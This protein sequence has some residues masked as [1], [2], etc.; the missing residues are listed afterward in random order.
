MQEGLEYLSTIVNSIICIPDA[1][2]ITYGKDKY[3]F[4]AMGQDATTNEYFAV[5]AIYDTIC[6]I[7]RKIKYAFE[8]VLACDFSEKIAEY[9]PFS[10]PNEQEF[11]AMYHVENM[12]FRISILWDLL[13]QLCN[14]IFRTGIAPEDIHYNRYFRNHVYGEKLIPICVDVVNYLDEKDDLSADV[15]P[16][17]GN[18]KYLNDFRNQMTHRTSPNISSISIL[19]TTL[20]PPVMYVLHR[21]TED[22]YTVSSFLCRLINQYLESHKDWSPFGTALSQEN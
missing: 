18:H 6:D 21:A 20:R 17:P 3:V 22:Y 19:G 4:S 15:N 9:D 2:R 8:K 5:S 7:D 14:V 16:W 10:E 1:F 11:T 12:V 13:A